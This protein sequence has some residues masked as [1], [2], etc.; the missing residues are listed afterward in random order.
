MTEGEP[1]QDCLVCLNASGL[2]YSLTGYT[3]SI[4]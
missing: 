4:R 2:A 1:L 3:V